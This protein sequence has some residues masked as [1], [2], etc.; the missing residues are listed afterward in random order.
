MGSP[1]P[2]SSDARQ[3][4]RELADPDVA[5]FLQGYFKTGA[6]EYGEGDLFVGVRVPALR[7]LAR[8]LR[9]AS[10]AEA[11]DLLRAAVHEE[12][13]LALLLLTDAYARGDA[14]AQAEIFRV[15]LDH[16]RYINNWDLVDTSAPLIVGRHLEHRD[17]RL[18]RRLA[19]SPLLWERRIAMVATFH[20]IKQDDYDDAIAIAALLLDDEHD[21][22]HKAAGWMLREVGKRHTGTLRAFLDRHAPRMPRTMLRYAIERLPERTRRAY[23]GVPRAKAAPR[24][25]AKEPRRGRP[26]N[27]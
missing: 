12:R 18:L 4:L 21:L 22:M 8:E 9:G 26:D 15:Y 17:R 7:R 6:G 14:R 10:I 20:F 23:L 5:R 25:S 11:T 3:R 13:L 1:S 19:R 27:L 16:T 2:S 24:R